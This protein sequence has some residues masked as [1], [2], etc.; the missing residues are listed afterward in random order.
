MRARANVSTSDSFSAATL[1]IK[2]WYFRY[3]AP[4]RS[5]AQM[6]RPKC[7]MNVCQTPDV[8]EA[9]SLHL[10]VQPNWSELPVVVLLDRSVA[11]HRVRSLLDKAWPGARQIYCQRPVAAL[12]LIT[13]VQSAL[14][15]RRLP[16]GIPVRAAVFSLLMCFAMKASPPIG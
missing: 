14:A 5:K 2:A 11:H 8:I 1:I 7:S 16:P 9:V 13:G 15:V 12:E 3:I 10:L 4:V 6:R